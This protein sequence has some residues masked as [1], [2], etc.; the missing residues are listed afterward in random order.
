[1]NHRAIK[2]DYYSAQVLYNYKE[3]GKNLIIVFGR[4][5]EIKINE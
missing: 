1:M 3:F 2:F 5:A 4:Y